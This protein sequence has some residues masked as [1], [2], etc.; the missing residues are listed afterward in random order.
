M[1]NRDFVLQAVKRMPANASL[2]TILRELHEHL[3]AESVKRALARSEHGDKGV[4]AEEVRKL[5]EGW[6]RDAKPKA[7]A[8]R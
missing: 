3:L 6:I 4:P 7:R 5:L 8:R 1:N 2:Q